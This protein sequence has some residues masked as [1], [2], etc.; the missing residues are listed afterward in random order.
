MQKTFLVETKRAK[1][2]ID[3]TSQV[4]SSID[5][6]EEGLCLV[7]NLHTTCSV[8][9]GEFEPGLDQDFINM[10]EQ[11]KP[12]GPFKHAH[13]PDHAPSHLFSS[14]VGEQVL[15]PV[16]SGQMVL[17]TWQS[18]MLVEFDGPRSRKIVVQTIGQTK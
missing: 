10:F 14:M 8:M 16:K 12:K 18:I 11:L 5:N 4:E 2:V 3:I 1:E 9:L 6:V 7:F 15:V 13:E 17:G